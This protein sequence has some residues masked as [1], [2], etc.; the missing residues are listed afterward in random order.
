MKFLF[1]FVL[2]VFVAHRAYSITD[3]QKYLDY[4]ESVAVNES[5]ITENGDF[6]SQRQKLYDAK[7]FPNGNAITGV[8]SFAC[9]DMAARSPQIPTSVHALRANDIN[10]IAAMGD[11]LTAGLGA[12]AQ[13]LVE[14]T[15]EYRG[16]AF[17]IG[18][19][20]DLKF[21]ATLPNIVNQFSPL[22]V[23]A[24]HR[25]APA[26]FQKFAQM[27]VAVSG[28]R[29][30]N[31]TAQATDLVERLKTDDRINI[32][33]DWKLVTIFIGSNDMCDYCRDKVRYAPEKYK[34]NIIAAINILKASLPRTLVNIISP[35]HVE[36]LNQVNA[37]S[38]YCTQLHKISC[39]CA[40]DPSLPSIV[41][42]YQAM[43]RSIES[44]FAGSDDFTVVV[45]TFMEDT[46]LPR[47]PSGKPDLS[48]FAP[49]CFHF[50]HWG[51]AMMAKALWNN[52]HE[53]VGKKA[54]TYQVE[55]M[56]LKCPDS[57]C[58]LIRTSANSASCN[59]Y[60]DPSV[61]LLRT[62]QLTNAMVQPAVTDKDAYVPQYGA[63][64]VPIIVDQRGAGTT[65]TLVLVGLALGLIFGLVVGSLV[66]HMFVNSKRPRSIVPT[67]K[68]PLLAGQHGNTAHQRDGDSNYVQIY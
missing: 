64:G 46:Q 9:P 51:H 33:T 7:F 2:L 40:T 41:K 37:I 34:S 4:I 12:G 30:D 15:M 19:D 49:D 35:E 63:Q 54:S 55:T 66:Y 25:I 16:L 27:N 24:S 32:A 26:W 31:L 42:Q 28:S 44:E 47:D 3:I 58:P 56:S 6:L 61:K 8:P 45:Q 1:S 48:F 39:P 18:G 36:F 53:P 43:A 60:F 20:S 65:T 10:V 13:S 62:P 68:T 14:L 11:S 38:T 59:K 21:S 22:V 23:G 67:E 29:A 50:S 57:T 17:S 5:A 52:M